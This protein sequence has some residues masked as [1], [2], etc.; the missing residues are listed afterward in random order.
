MYRQMTTEQIRA[1]TCPQVSNIL[2]WVLLGD[3]SIVVSVFIVIPFGT[4]LP[5]ILA[6]KKEDG[7]QRRHQNQG[8][9]ICEVVLFRHLQPEHSHRRLWKTKTNRELNG[10]PRQK[11]I[12]TTNYHDSKG[13]HNR[14]P[15]SFLHGNFQVKSSSP[16][17]LSSYCKS[18]PLVAFIYAKR[19][20]GNS[21]HAAFL[22]FVIGE[23]IQNE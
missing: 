5:V 6:N 2:A 8:R 1:R 16:L 14:S 4:S 13:T 15:P 21:K 11:K 17:L 7:V 3:N 19:K 23:G 20:G 9:S 10:A 12:G 22:S 18:L